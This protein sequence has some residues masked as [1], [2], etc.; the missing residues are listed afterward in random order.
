MKG[1][2]GSDL[3]QLGVLRTGSGP[4]NPDVR[5]YYNLGDRPCQLRIAV[6]QNLYFSLGRAP[7]TV[8]QN[9][10]SQPF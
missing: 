6:L 2:R 3:S 7:A 9:L 5:A 4:F 8:R 1:T 10:T